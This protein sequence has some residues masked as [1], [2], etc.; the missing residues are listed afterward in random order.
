MIRAGVDLEDSKAPKFRS[1]LGIGDGVIA[2]EP[3]GVPPKVTAWH[4]IA[5]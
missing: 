3:K 2:P 1:I 4:G 5:R